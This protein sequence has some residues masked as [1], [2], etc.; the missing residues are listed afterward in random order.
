[1]YYL[2]M[3]K[4]PSFLSS[5]AEMTGTDFASFDTDENLRMLAPIVAAYVRPSTCSTSD[6]Y[7]STDPLLL[8]PQLAQ[9]D[10]RHSSESNFSSLCRTLSS[11]AETPWV[12]AMFAFFATS[13]W[14]ELVDETGLPLKDRVAVSLRFLSDSEVRFLTLF[15]PRTFLRQRPALTDSYPP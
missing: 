14:R 3:C 1:M 9:K 6:S 4:G 10:S 13:D 5:P 7:P 8:L 11:D 15:L 2:R 12:R